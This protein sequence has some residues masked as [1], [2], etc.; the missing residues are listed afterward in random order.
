MCVTS[1]RGQHIHRGM[2]LWNGR[3]L[4]R[5]Q[6]DSLDSYFGV[7]AR[8][9]IGRCS[10]C[11]IDISH[12]RSSIACESL[13]PH[14]RRTAGRQPV[15]PFEPAHSLREIGRLPREH[16]DSA[17]GRLGGLG[18]RVSAQRPPR[19][20]RSPALRSPPIVPLQ[21]G[22]LAPHRQ[23]TGHQLIRRTWFGSGWGVFSAG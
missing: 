4:L 21:A 19:R 12:Y 22:R 11:G 9:A 20:P 6:P 7:T 10:A 23:P 1:R 18:Q 8:A 14:T 13:L 16:D 2:A 17:Q 5:S 15:P 3:R